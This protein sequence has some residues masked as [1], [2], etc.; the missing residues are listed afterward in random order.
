MTATATFSAQL[1]KLCGQVEAVRNKFQSTKARPVKGEEEAFRSFASRITQAAAELSEAIRTFTDSV[2]DVE[3]SKLLAQ[4]RERDAINQV[5]KTILKR[6]LNQIF[7]G[8]EDSAL[9]SKQV[10]ARK[11]VLRKRCA[12]ISDLRPETVVR[13]A[14]SFPPSVWAV[15]TMSQNTFDYLTEGLDS[16]KTG[17]LSS[18]ICTVLRTLEAEEPLNQYHQYHDLVQSLASLDDTSRGQ[19]LASDE[20]TASPLN[21]GQPMKQMRAENEPKDSL[22]QQPGYNVGLTDQLLEKSRP[23]NHKSVVNLQFSNLLSFLLQYQDQAP[24]L[25]MICS[26]GDMRIEL[27]IRLSEALIQYMLAL[28]TASAKVSH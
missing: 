27:S 11:K 23:A 5:N 14:N 13:W 8:P 6:N 25:H 15:G 9:D 4:A 19:A 20:E 22:L 28:G 7:K 17:P 18:D 10:K 21:T 12:T 2:P 16:E 26:W 24:N 1:D 3:G